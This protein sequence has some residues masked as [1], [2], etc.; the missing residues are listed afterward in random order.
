[1]NIARSYGSLMREAPWL[2]A[3]FVMPIILR[4]IGKEPNSTDDSIFFGT[5]F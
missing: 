3:A 1:M 2:D 5:W 4:G